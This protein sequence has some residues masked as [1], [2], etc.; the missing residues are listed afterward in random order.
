MGQNGIAGGMASNTWEGLN[1]L[2][3]TQSVGIKQQLC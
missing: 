3:R 1:N 2:S